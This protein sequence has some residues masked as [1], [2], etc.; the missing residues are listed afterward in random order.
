MIDDAEKFTNEMHDPCARSRCLQE[1]TTQKHLQKAPVWSRPNTLRRLSQKCFYNSKVLERS[2][3][4]VPFYEE[5]VGAF[6][7]SEVL[8]HFLVEQVSSLQSKSSPCRASL[9]L[10]EQVSSL[11]SKLSPCR[12]SLLKSKTWWASLGLRSVRGPTQRMGS[13]FFGPVDMGLLGS[14]SLISYFILFNDIFMI[15]SS[16]RTKIK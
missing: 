10:A 9:I 11:Q 16:S 5:D 6:Y 3:S 7:S 13:T 12:A 2:Q 14:P 1:R 8:P 4:R 15:L